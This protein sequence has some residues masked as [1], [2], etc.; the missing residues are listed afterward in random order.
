MRY[1][2]RLFWPGVVALA[3]VMALAAAG[4]ARNASLAPVAS[5]AAPVTRRSA[6]ASDLTAA[7]AVQTMQGY[8]E[9][10]SA[11]GR[12]DYRQAANLLARLERTGGLTPGQRAFCGSQEQLC[13]GH[14][15]SKSPPASLEA[16]RHREY[17]DSGGLKAPTA[18]DRGLKSSSVESH[19]S[20][21]ADVNAGGAGA[22][23]DCGPRALLL[24][25]DALG[26]RAS[27]PALTKA[28]GMGPRGTSLQGLKRAAESLKLKAEGVQA[29]REALPDVTTPAIAWTHRDH[30]ITLLAL[31]GRGEGG[32]ATIRDPNEPHER[33]IS[34]ES[35][36]QSSGG[37]LLTLSR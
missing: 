7:A 5:I 25:C 36:L 20:A 6:M 4:C 9:A 14:V 27:L 19:R 37:Y 16:Q 2:I 21:V 23:G 29:S 24:A 30:F 17:A 34:Q 26:V 35:L 1:G 22:A 8:R 3:P 15:L 12:G 32:T 13:L 31:S 18:V 11:C 28:A 33:T 10:K